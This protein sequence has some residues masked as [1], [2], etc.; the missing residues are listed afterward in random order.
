MAGSPEAEARAVACAV[1]RTA[2]TVAVVG[3]PLGTAS[4]Q[5]KGRSLETGPDLRFLG[6]GGRI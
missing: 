6:G 5:Q 1:P 3:I 4:G 2:P